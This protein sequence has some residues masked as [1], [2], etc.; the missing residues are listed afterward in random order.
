MCCLKMIKG[1]QTGQAQNVINNQY[2]T[3][4]LQ[5]N[6]ITIYL[7]QS[8]LPNLFDC[9][10]NCIYVFNHSVNLPLNVLLACVLVIV[11][12][13]LLFSC[14]SKN[15]NLRRYVSFTYIWSSQKPVYIDVK[16]LCTP[17]STHLLVSLFMFYLMC[18]SF[19][20]FCYRT[21]L[22]LS[23]CLSIRSSCTC[24]FN[25]LH[26]SHWSY[27]L[28]QSFFSSYYFLLLLF[29]NSFSSVH[30]GPFYAVSYCVSV[31]QN[32][33]S[34]LMEQSSVVHKMHQ[35]ERYFQIL[36]FL[37]LLLNHFLFTFILPFSFQPR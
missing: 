4:S 17:S 8:V 25:Y 1:M 2:V 18:T 32:N 31:K 29:I 34:Y 12:Y 19:S 6:L 24:L 11:F 35:F 30:T 21:Y 13:V 15:T 37:I 5:L 33:I 23:V 26:S 16:L 9:K 3:C 22:C 28:V 36:P 20:S 10:Q 7:F 27:I 14:L